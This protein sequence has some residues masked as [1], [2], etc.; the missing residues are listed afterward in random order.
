MQ[1]LEG[2]PNRN[3]R[4]NAVPLFWHTH[5]SNNTETVMWMKYVWGKRVYKDP[6]PYLLSISKFAPHEKKHEERCVAIDTFNL[7]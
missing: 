2:L 5:F 4:M 3:L 7:F 1:R 6:K